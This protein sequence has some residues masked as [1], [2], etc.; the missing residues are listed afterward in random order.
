MMEKDTETDKKMQRRH[1]SAT[2]GMNTRRKKGDFDY[3]ELNL[4]W[5]EELAYYIAY[6]KFKVYKLP[7]DNGDF[8]YRILDEYGDKILTIISARNVMF[9]PRRRRRK[10][11]S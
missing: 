7:L 5:E 4:R 10:R 11:R 3:S 2:K 1:N 9:S 6:N 8:E